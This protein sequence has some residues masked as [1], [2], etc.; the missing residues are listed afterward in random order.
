MA[1]SPVQPGLP[2]MQVRSGRPHGGLR[3]P[4]A[5]RGRGKGGLPRAP[6]A[7]ARR[8]RREPSALAERGLRGALS[9][10]GPRGGGG[11]GVFPPPRCSHF[12]ATSENPRSGG[13]RARL[14]TFSALQCPSV[15]LARRGRGWSLPLAQG[16]AGLADA[17][18]RPCDKAVVFKQPEW[19]SAG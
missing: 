8:N 6:G 3:G 11:R 13:N 4:A 1:H 12:N 14:L 7:V 2:G 18:C 5:A 9:I 10:F 15:G 16:A 19:L 17:I